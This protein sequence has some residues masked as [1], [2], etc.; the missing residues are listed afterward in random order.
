MSQSAS[1]LINS[2]QPMFSS[3]ES[4][5][6]EPT[7]IG[8]NVN[9]SLTWN[10]VYNTLKKNTSKVYENKAYLA[11]AGTG[12]EK[13]NVKTNWKR[14]LRGNATGNHTENE[15]L[16]SFDKFARSNLT[17][18]AR[19]NIN[20][21]TTERLITNH[22]NSSSNPISDL[23]TTH[24]NSTITD[25]DF[26]TTYRDFLTTNSDFTTTN[27]S[28][29]TSDSTT[30]RL[31][32]NNA[33]VGLSYR[34]SSGNNLSDFV[35]EILKDATTTTKYEL[36]QN[37]RYNNN[38]ATFTITGPCQGLLCET[39]NK[40]M[41]PIEGAVNLTL[42]NGTSNLTGDPPLNWSILVLML[43]VVGGLLGNILVCLAIL[44][45]KKLQN[46]TNYFMLSLAIADVL[47]SAVVMPLGII[48]EFYG[49][50]TLGL[51]LC[52]LY[53][54][55]DVMLCTSS[56][57]HM[58]CISLDRY[59][60]IRNPLKTRN[61]S[62]RIVIVKI[63]IVWVISL[64][65]SSP[66]VILGILDPINVLDE[67]H[68]MCGIA[69]INFRIYGSISAFF[70]PL[71]IMV[72]TYSLTIHLLWGL[73]QKANGNPGKD[74][75]G[76]MMRRSK[77]KS[78]RKVSTKNNHVC[79]NKEMCDSD[80]N[81][82]S[83]PPEI[84][85]PKMSHKLMRKAAFMKSTSLDELDSGCTINGSMRNGHEVYTKNGN[86][87]KNGKF[88]KL[89]SAD[90]DD[91]P[92]ELELLNTSPT[93][94]ESSDQGSPPEHHKIKN[95]LMTPR[96]KAVAAFLNTRSINTKKSAAVRTEQKAAK[97]LGVIF[98]IFICC[99]VPFFVVNVTTAICDIL[100]YR[101]TMDP[102]LFTVFLWLGYVS[103]TINPIIYTIFNKNFRKAFKLLMK[104]Q[105]AELRN[106]SPLNF[107]VANGY[108]TY[109]VTSYA[110]Y[111]FRS[112]TPTIAEMQ[113]YSKQTSA[114]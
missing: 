101:L 71:L 46:V 55:S 12:R 54:F 45:E 37:M 87:R 114:S 80:N 102:I 94:S 56:I 41:D 61:K 26:N 11:G 23:I 92:S 91:G 112:N 21:T 27:S 30:T 106:P 38:I 86:F 53:S 107:L 78:R 1:G 67:V 74:G 65:I 39:S 111:R 64:A 14:W 47:V 66:I 60:G 73:A 7:H 105:W 98:V 4:E 20:E 10:T 33:K 32:E 25:S 50:W 89:N 15:Q 63:V 34:W 42:G 95:K 77:S 81:L 96:V 68:G 19:W 100:E 13:F 16:E 40:S 48:N 49:K 93:N 110:A 31:V 52:I 58:C 24:S 108:T 82:H 76:P 88:R 43:F 5:L 99:W 6:L 103:S 8:Y 59:L 104:C 72:V 83:L 109:A 84:P 57:M 79:F 62:M 36:A 51:E 29:T 70:I 85:P 17:S 3:V 44:M 28:F 9:E 2:L 97:V 18:N 22:V 90:H 35:T 113:E 69:N 75:R